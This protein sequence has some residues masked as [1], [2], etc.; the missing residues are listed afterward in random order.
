MGKQKLA[1]AALLLVAAIAIVDIDTPSVDAQAAPAIG[2]QTLEDA[3]VVVEGHVKA[4]NLLVVDG[5][6]H[7]AYEVSVRNRFKG[8]TP[9]VI[10]VVV[11]G[12]TFPDGRTLQVSHAGEL[13]VGD[14]SH[15]ALGPAGNVVAGSVAAS[16]G[17]D[18]AAVFQVVNGDAGVA[19]ISG[20]LGTAGFSGASD[21]K[22]HGLSWDSFATAVPF[23]V[24]TAGSPIDAAQT[25]SAVRDAAQEW[26]DDPA[27][28]IDFS[29][30]GSTSAAAPGLG[31]GINTIAFRNI[32]GAV[33]LAQAHW[34]SASGGGMTEFDIVVNTKYNF[35]NGSG[36]GTWYDLGSTL[37]HEFGHVLGLSHVPATSEIM[38]S[39]V[40]SNTVSHLG[41]GDL[42]AV[43]RLYPDDSG[44]HCNG[45]VAT[46]EIGRGQSPTNGDDV[47]VGTEGND[48]IDGLG[49]NDV[50]CAL[51]GD[52][53]VMG[54]FGDDIVFG[55]TGNDT[56]HGDH[57]RD[58]LWGQDG[59]DVIHGG[60]LGDRIHGGE[61]HD[62]LNGDGGWDKIEGD[63]GADTIHGGYGGD[64]IAGGDGPDRIFGENGPDRIWGNGGADEI[65]AGRGRDVVR[66]GGGPDVIFGDGGPDKISGN[67]GGDTIHGGRGWDQLFGDGGWDTINGD[68]GW[69]TM[70][71]GDA[72]D[73]CDGGWGKDSASSCETAIRTP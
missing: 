46:V 18:P 62:T 7:T 69:D 65:D 41:A 42:A 27:S 63:R 1:V 48:V 28:A 45:L 66:G 50:I 52:D 23:R 13:E 16:N 43:R 54:G 5:T 32:G 71:G 49:G 40:M 61:G 20:P 24:N 47:I 60:E 3:P 8:D 70:D 25:I 2:A 53:R 39:S 15:L 35:A 64:R 34:I 4:E 55:G 37:L 31:D 6:P 72:M 17:T 26:E 10:Q 57:G 59:D 68:G 67:F 19:T 30:E 29:Y 56:I 21:Y 12:G 73:V 51:G 33:Y 36:S 11:M 58:E 22:L 14:I 44:S 9:A 38:S